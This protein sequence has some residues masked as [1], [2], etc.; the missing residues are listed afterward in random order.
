MR[1]LGKSV[2][3]IIPAEQAI[4]MEFIRSSILTQSDDFRSHFENLCLQYDLDAQPLISCIDIAE[5]EVNKSGGKFQIILPYS[6][7]MAC[8]IEEFSAEL[9]ERCSY[10]RDS[11]GIHV[12]LLAPSIVGEV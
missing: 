9:R 11:R 6:I 10:T 12:Q 8:R 3:I 7:Y 2:F 4:T 5:L 1:V